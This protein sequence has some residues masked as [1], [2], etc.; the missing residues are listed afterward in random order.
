MGGGRIAKTKEALQYFVRALPEGCKF[1]I[2]GFGSEVKLLFPTS[3]TYSS[4]SLQQATY[5]VDKIEADLGG[6]ELLAPLKGIFSNQ[7]ELGF[8]NIFVLT[9]GL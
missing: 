4:E 5:H 6:T 3:Q 9:D 2:I 8:R 7:P 1:N